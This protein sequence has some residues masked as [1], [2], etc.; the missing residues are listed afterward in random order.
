[1]CSAAGSR[2]LKKW[3]VRPLRDEK[4][5]NQRLDMIAYLNKNFLLREQLKESLSELYDIERLIARIGYGNANGKDCVRLQKSLQQAPAIMKIVSGS[6]LY[7]EYDDIDCCESLNKLLQKAIVDDPPVSTR[8]GGIFRSGYNDQLDQYRSIQTDGRKWLTELEQKEKERTG[9]KNLRIGYNRVFGYYIEISKGNLP[10]VQSEWG[11]QRKQTL[12]TGE[13]FITEELKEREDA[14]IHAEERA[15]NLESELFEQLME[16][17]KGYL[18]RLQR[19][20]ACLAC[21]DSLYSLS[22]ISSQHGYVRPIFNN[23]GIMSIKQGRH[24]IMETITEYIPNDVVL[25]REKRV[26]IITGPNMGGKSTYMRQA[27]LIV[28]MAQMGCYVPAKKAEL[29]I[30]DQIFTRIGSSDDILAGQS[31][32]MVEMSEANNALQKATRDSLILFDEIGRGTA[33]YDGMALAQ[34]I[35]EYI[36]VAIEAKTLFSTHYHELTALENSMNGIVNKHVA[37]LEDNDKIEF[38]YKVQNGKANR[39]YG[40]HV[41]AL[42]KLPETVLERATALLKELESKKQTKNDLA[43]IVM[44]EKEDPKL[45]EVKTVLQQVDVNNITPIEA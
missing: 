7:P 44:V 14:I 39:S 41:A 23:D 1:T 18:S 40:I 11:Y 20:S 32:F 21:I 27:A 38:L 3:I 35:L 29:P 8:D 22:V 30:F 36:D 25:D 34:A 4:A 13:R 24:P 5:I 42:A 2:N 17:V 26:Q 6:G 15:I 45:K 16:T 31:T 28:I 37:V 33:T 12:T 43:Q 19:L 10:L 9:I